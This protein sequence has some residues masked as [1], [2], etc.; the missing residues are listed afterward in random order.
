MH[1]APLTRRSP[2]RVIVTSIGRLV[3]VT[4]LD[5]PESMDVVFDTSYQF[6]TELEWVIAELTCVMLVFC[7][8][9]LPKIISE[10]TT[11]LTGKVNDLWRSCTGRGC[12]S[13]G[14]GSRFSI[15]SWNKGQT[16]AR[17]TGGHLTGTSRERI[18]DEESVQNQPTQPNTIELASLDDC[19]VKSNRDVPPQ[20]HN[21]TLRAWNL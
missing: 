18:N 13:H 20:E 4:G 6:S 10:R 21:T 15:K 12:D 17:I 16:W 1:Y 3:G 9:A 5:Y 8:P 2:F 7:V 11:L 19:H 14:S